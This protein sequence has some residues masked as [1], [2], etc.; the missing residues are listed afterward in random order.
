[1]SMV[2]FLEELL[3]FFIRTAPEEGLKKATTFTKATGIPQFVPRTVQRGLVTGANLCARLRAVRDTG[4][5]TSLKEEVDGRALSRSRFSAEDNIALNARELRASA[6]RWTCHTVSNKPW[7]CVTFGLWL[8][9]TVEE[10]VKS[11]A[12]RTPLMVALLC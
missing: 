8:Q 6:Y 3:E 7:N 1:M 5:S 11:P 2:P 9:V 12:I 4:Q 10:P